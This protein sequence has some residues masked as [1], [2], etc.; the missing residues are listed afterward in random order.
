MNEQA[1]SSSSVVN[2]QVTTSRHH[3][4]QDP[5]CKFELKGA[6]LA[7]G[8]RLY[9]TFFLYPF[10]IFLPFSIASS[11]NIPISKVPFFEYEIY[12]VFHE[13]ISWKNQNLVTKLENL[14][15][16]K[17]GRLINMIFVQKNFLKKLT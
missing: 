16:M 11:W 14:I 10:H 12:V 13:V 5:G 8:G 7:T 15:F 3:S 6:S 17:D 9:I 4:F 1:A 2:P